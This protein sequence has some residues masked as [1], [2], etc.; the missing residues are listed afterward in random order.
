MSKDVMLSC[1]NTYRSIVTFA[2]ECA[3]YVLL[4]LVYGLFMNHRQAQAGCFCPIQIVN[5]FLMLLSYINELGASY[6]S[7]YA[8][9]WITP[10]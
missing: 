2:T 10:S 9:R 7:I 5:A 1:F 4:L 3:L 8:R 6:V